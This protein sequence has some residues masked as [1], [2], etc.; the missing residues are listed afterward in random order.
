MWRLG[1]VWIAAA[2]V[3]L[4]SE[5][6]ASLREKLKAPVIWATLTNGWHDYWPTSKAMLEGGYE[7]SQVP[8]GFTSGDGEKLIEE[9]VAL[10]ETIKK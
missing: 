4:F 5:L 3:E 2:P 1:D 10:A 8:E 7:P 9:M 6:G